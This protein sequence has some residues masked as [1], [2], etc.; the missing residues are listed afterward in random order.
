[1]SLPLKLD[2]I[3]KPIIPQSLWRLFGF[4]GGILCLYFNGYW[5][6]IYICLL[7]VYGIGLCNSIEIHIENEIQIIKNYNKMG[8]VIVYLKQ[9]YPNTGFMTKNILNIEL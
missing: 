7:G 6:K 8:R 2:D 1:M 4:I 9:I 5:L 3:V